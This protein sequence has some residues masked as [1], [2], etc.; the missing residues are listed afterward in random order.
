[1]PTLDKPGA[2]LAA[3]GAAAATLALAA[4]SPAFAQDG[5]GGPHPPNEIDVSTSVFGGAAPEGEA[6]SDYGLSDAG[7]GAYIEIADVDDTL[8]GLD[9]VQVSYHY[10]DLGFLDFEFSLEGDGYACT[11]DGSI[12]NCQ[13][14]PDGGVVK[15]W[16]KMI[17]HELAIPGDSGQY[18]L[19]A[20]YI[21]DGEIIAAWEDETF[22]L[23]RWFLDQADLGSDGEEPPVEEEEHYEFAY[24]DHVLQGADLG[25]TVTA[26]PQIQVDGNAGEDRVGSVVWFTD[27]V[28]IDMWADPDVV[29][30]GYEMDADSAS[31]V[32][33]YD[34]C[35]KFEVWLICLVT[36]WTPEVGKTY[37]PSESSPIQYTIDNKVEENH[38]GVYSAF[39]VNQEALD[40]YVAEFGLDLDG[41]SKFSL[42]AV[43]EGEV[44]SEEYF[45]EGEGWIYF[46]GSVENAAGE[47]ADPKL[48]TTGSSSV[49]MI[50][51][52]AAAIVAGA[53][54]FFVMRRR[55]TAASW[56]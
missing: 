27:A 14:N 12:Y 54:V 15:I 38:V 25:K 17:P 40:Y 23:D 36:D 50:S 34:N 39:D 19:Y 29:Y 51:A 47:S 56:E 5:E 21:S 22:T 30:D 45:Y 26:A 32:D 41:A 48:P 11:D 20:S 46:E 43:D 33:A 35:A 37:R 24:L 18:S 4:G 9:A 28:D 8:Q 7:V 44:A 2:R 52:A 10:S 3:A 55:K 49:V 31:V 42:S 6:W 53:V 16:M 1:M 13:V